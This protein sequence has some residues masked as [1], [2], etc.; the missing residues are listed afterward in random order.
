[1]SIAHANKCYK[2]QLLMHPNDNCGEDLLMKHSQT[3]F[4]IHS[5]VLSTHFLQMGHVLVS[6]TT[7]ILEFDVHKSAENQK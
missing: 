4:F 2:Q 5:K 1:M 3:V 7:M 6:V